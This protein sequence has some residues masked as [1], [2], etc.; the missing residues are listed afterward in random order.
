MEPAVSFALD[1]YQPIAFHR[2][3]ELMR[4]APAPLP[5]PVA[6]PSAAPAPAAV[7]AP[8]PPAP[9]TEPIAAYVVGI[10]ATATLR[11][12]LTNFLDAAG[13]RLDV[14]VSV[15]VADGPEVVWVL[16]DQVP[17]QVRALPRYPATRPADAAAALA[18]TAGV[19][20]GD[21]DVHPARR[22]LVVLVWDRPPAPVALPPGLAS[23]LVLHCADAVVP[24]PINGAAGPWLLSRSRPG[25]RSGVLAQ[26][27]RLLDDWAAFAAVPA[28]LLLSRLDD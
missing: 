24:V 7:P 27:G 8:A 21:A 2:Q 12:Q 19:V 14:R 15:G 5:P 17:A 23:A 1:R 18:E 11:G 3:P 10:D 16:R 6:A 25:V 4:A 13:A 9:A 22:R 28:D 26:A 20:A